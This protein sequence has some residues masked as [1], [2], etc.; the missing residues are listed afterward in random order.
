MRITIAAAGKF[1]RGPERVLYENYVERLS[2]PVALKEIE[3]GAKLGPPA[4]RAK[5]AERLLGA[6]P[7]GAVLIALDETGSALPSR[8][9][10]AR[11]GRWR[12]DGMAELGFIIGGAEGLDHALIGGAELVLSL[13]PMTWPHLMVRAMLAEQLYRAE[14]ILRG[15][16]YHRG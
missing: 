16:P 3:E 4:R 14:A 7:D 6:M 1:R 13:G 10:A 12:D 2:W 11:I 5:E 9:F 8:A 15:H